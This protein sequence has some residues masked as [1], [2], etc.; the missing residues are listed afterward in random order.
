MNIE[1]RGRRAGKTYRLLHWLKV[2]NGVIVCIDE[3][4]ADFTR[5]AARA[6]NSGWNE[7]YVKT[8]IISWHSRDCLQGTN[9]PVAVDNADMILT[10]MLGGR[11]PDRVT[12]TGVAI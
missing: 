10:H 8:H 6:F 4:V 5:A 1:V 12:F 3:Q 2:T 7:E 11:Y 9:Y